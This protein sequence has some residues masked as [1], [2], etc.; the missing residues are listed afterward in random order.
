[1][2]ASRALLAAMLVLAS[3]R[4][5]AGE[6]TFAADLGAGYDSNLGN[7]GD[8]HDT[9]D[10]VAT[11][12][13]ASVTW[14]Q[15]FGLFTA[16]QVRANFASEQFGDVADL[17]SERGALRL[18]VLHKPGKGFYT[19]VLAASVAAG[20]RDYGS[21]I[22][23]GSDQRAA[24]SLAMPLT[25]AIQWRL[26]ASQTQRE[27]DGRAF[28]LGT[29]SY[30][31]DLDWLVSSGLTLYG[32]VRRDQGDFVV[33]TN[34]EGE[35]SPK[36]EH[37]YLE[38]IASVIEADPAFGNDWWAF[39]ID[40]SAMIVTGGLNVALTPDLSLDLQALRAVTTVGKFSYERLI[41]SLGLLYRW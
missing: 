40:A 36:R 34:G 1:M 19:P 8:D 7:A 28:D 18:K 25:T 10:S 23:D 38:P 22:R 2:T 13:G 6:W 3:G 27:A 17:S 15:R 16:L 26:E 21:K 41:G 24:V 39:R 4:A 35:V 32:G 33:T 11:L 30:S 20:V 12:A 9:R 29:T 5:A 31:L 37:R 14:E